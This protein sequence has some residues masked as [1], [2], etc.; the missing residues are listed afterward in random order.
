MTKQKIL[1]VLAALFL[2]AALGFQIT[3]PEED[4]AAIT[5]VVTELADSFDME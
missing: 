5:G 1:A 2:I 3:I 4:K